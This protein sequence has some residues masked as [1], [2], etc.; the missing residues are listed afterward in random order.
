MQG[1]FPSGQTHSIVSIRFISIY[2][3]C[4]LSQ[5]AIPYENHPC[6]NMDDVSCNTF[7]LF[8]F[9]KHKHVLKGMIAA[10]RSQWRIRGA[11]RLSGSTVK[12]LPWVSGTWSRG[13]WGAVGWGD[14]SS[15]HG[16][17][18]WEG[19]MVE[20]NRWMCI[21]YHRDLSWWSWQGW[22]I[23]VCVCGCVWVCVVVCVCVCV[24]VLACHG[25][26]WWCHECKCKS[27]VE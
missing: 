27:A 13:E 10:C 21:I 2:F 5:T 3:Y 6:S 25:S 18:R 8:M 26:V 23:Y 22:N 17:W 19:G 15:S 11:E 20:L 9:P 12:G 16:V 4:I 7:K 1:I 24:C 14:G